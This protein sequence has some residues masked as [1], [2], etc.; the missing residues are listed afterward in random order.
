M[1][2]TMIDEAWLNATVQAWPGAEAGV[3]PE[4]GTFVLTV[5]GKLFGL[6]GD[7]SGEPLLTVKGDP[8]DNEA[9]RQSFAEV[10]PGYHTNKRHWVSVRLDPRV[11]TLS[12]E[13]LAELL[14][15]S[16]ALVFASLTR[17]L[18]AELS[19]S[20]RRRGLTAG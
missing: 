3:K 9:L 6:F 2:E 1:P 15:E 5:G 10:L 19:E 14:E 11:C 20:H 4:W 13:H 17:Q 8:L 16:Y 7:A 18:Q 12:R